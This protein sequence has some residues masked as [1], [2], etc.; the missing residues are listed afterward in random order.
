[1]K[2]RYLC[3]ATFILG[4]LTFSKVHSE[5]HGITRLQGL[6]LR[7]A[8]FL[9]VYTQPPDS[10]GN[11]YASV[12]SVLRGN[13][14]HIGKNLILLN[15]TEQ[16]ISLCPNT[17]YLAVA[18]IGCG[19]RA[20][21][22]LGCFLFFYKD[23]YILPNTYVNMIFLIRQWNKTQVIDRG[24]FDSPRS[25][26]EIIEVVNVQRPELDK[27]YKEYL[28]SKPGFSGKVTLKFTIASSGDIVSINIVSSKTDY[29][30]FD[31]AI[32]N[33]VAKW[34][35]KA[36]KRG[37]TTPTIPFNFTEEMLSEP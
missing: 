1:M 29:P 27:I 19:E 22:K 12:D 2:I 36:I 17:Y 18:G 35:W 30:E 33:A 20:D 25:K 24:G 9:R 5:E 4:L 34:K 26:K 11:M 7:E 23:D 37:N 32:K 3:F 14:T 15:G 21:V 31:E 16:E 10:N 8:A 28:K 13:K 6:P